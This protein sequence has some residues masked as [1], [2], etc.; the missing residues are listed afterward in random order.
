M[1][2]LI[3]TSLSAMR[4][5]EARQ[6]ATANNIANASTPGFRADV[7]IAQAVWLRG[8]TV[9]TRAMASEE[10]IATDMRAGVTTPTGR[11]L[12]LSV[13]GTG[14]IAVQ[15]QNG[16]E[17]YT[18]RGDLQIAATG[19]VTTGDGHPVLGSK[20]PLILPAA[21]RV[22]IAADGR[23]F[24][25][26][27]GGNAGTQQEIDRIKIVTAQASGVVKGVDG[28]L[29]AKGAAALPEDPDGRLTTGQLETSNVS[30]TTSLVQMIEA[31]R[32]WDAQ[33]K[34]IADARDLDSATA[35][36]MRLPD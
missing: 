29:R 9:E 20:G 21:D 15:A 8:G 11:D 14:L 26:P 24:I 22:T 32:A 16:E 28:L 7:A 23:V 1:D 12:D 2:R 19:L 10:V 4:A 5:A 17:A 35:D 18:R 30:T 34:L 36:L 6:T 3:Y 27:V 31:S 13:V 25:V 33:L